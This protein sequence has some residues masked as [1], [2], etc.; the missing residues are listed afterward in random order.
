MLVRVADRIVLVARTQR[1]ASLPMLP[2]LLRR[3]PSRIRSR[4]RQTLTSS[5]HPPRRGHYE[6]E[7]IRYEESR[8]MSDLEYQRAAKH[9]R[10]SNLW[11]LSHLCTDV[12]PNYH[13][14]TIRA[15]GLLLTIWVGEAGCCVLASCYAE[16]SSPCFLRSAANAAGVL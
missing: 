3:A 5:V 4:V 15:P 6:A 9:S 11:K 2:H 1:E 10:V 16:R 14:V 8:D 13:P 7:D 12:T